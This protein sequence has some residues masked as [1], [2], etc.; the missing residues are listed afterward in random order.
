MRPKNTSLQEFS[1]FFI[2]VDLLRVSRECCE[3]A[4]VL[5]WMEVVASD[6]LGDWLSRF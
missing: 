5:R 6:I 4:Y 2:L 1:Y 3:R